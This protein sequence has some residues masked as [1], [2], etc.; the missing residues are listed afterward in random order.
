MLPQHIPSLS[1]LRWVQ[2]GDRW[3]WVETRAPGPASSAPHGPCLSH[4]RMQSDAL[5]PVLEPGLLEEAQ[6]ALWHLDVHPHPSPSLTA[7][8]GAA[9]SSYIVPSAAQPPGV[10]PTLRRHVSPRTIRTSGIHCRSFSRNALSISS[11]QRL[12]T[13]AR[14][15][16][17]SRQAPHPHGAYHARDGH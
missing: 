13:E 4:I 2:A 3:R 16:G 10:S 14:T 6:E 5:I 11:C 9:P 8:H 1:R 12:C 17:K 15:V 7:P